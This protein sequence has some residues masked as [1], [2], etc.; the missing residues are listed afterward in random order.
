MLLESGATASLK[1]IAKF[2]ETMAETV[3]QVIAGSKVDRN[4][5]L[6]RIKVRIKSALSCE[7]GWETGSFF[8]PALY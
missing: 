3:K 6:E 2:P 7:K 1:N 8:K 5:G 4:F